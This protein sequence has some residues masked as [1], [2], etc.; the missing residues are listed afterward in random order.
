MLV[1]ATKMGFYRGSRKRPGAEFDM[2]ELDG[3]NPIKLPKWVQPADI[4]AADMP[5][6]EQRAYGAAKAAAGPK[7]KGTTA[8]KRV[9]NA[10]ANTSGGTDSED[11][12]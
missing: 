2:T 12:V 3:E 10:F 6:E 5:D 9:M 1:R 11:L 8:I 7:R 4:D